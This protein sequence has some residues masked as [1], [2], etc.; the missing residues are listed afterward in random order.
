MLEDIWKLIKK[1]KIELSALVL[2]LGSLI[3]LDIAN[4][5]RNREAYFKNPIVYSSQEDFL[6]DLEAEKKKLGLE[7][8]E[9]ICED[10][11][12]IEGGHSWKRGDKK[13]LVKF[14][15]KYK[16]KRVLR[17]ELYHIKKWEEEGLS[18]SGIL[19]SFSL[20]KYEEYRATSYSLKGVK[21]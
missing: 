21:S 8:L 1:R 14:N 5:Y 16:T 20:G 19:N 6:N 7:K 9:I 18:L 3:S 10:D 17:H 11:T 12:D 2:W 15:P 13:Y 4:V